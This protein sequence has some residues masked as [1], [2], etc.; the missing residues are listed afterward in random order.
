MRFISCKEPRHTTTR[1]NKIQ[2]IIGKQVKM[3]LD[4]LIPSSDIFWPLES[5]NGPQVLQAK[6]HSVSWKRPFQCFHYLLRPGGLSDMILYLRVGSLESY[7]CGCYNGM[8]LTL[9]GNACYFWITTSG[10]S[11]VG[12]YITSKLRPVPLCFKPVEKITLQIQYSMIMY[13][14]K[15]NIQ[16]PS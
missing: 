3:I 2:G 11:K 14:S 4:N 13:V 10:P 8:R 7:L 5:G 9:V 6:R 15:A 1:G 12:S 16:I